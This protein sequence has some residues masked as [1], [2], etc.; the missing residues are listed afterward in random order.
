MRRRFEKRGARMLSRLTDS[1]QN[2]SCFPYVLVQCIV[3]PRVDYLIQILPQTQ[4]RK[5]YPAK[6]VFSLVLRSKH[7]T[8]MSTDEAGS[9]GY[10]DIY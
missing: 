8:K 10:E 2:F 7:C 9:S 1:L 3:V 5:S 6:C 4:L